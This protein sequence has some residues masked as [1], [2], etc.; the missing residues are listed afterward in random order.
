MCAQSPISI[1]NEKTYEFINIDNPI[2]MKLFRTREAQKQNH[3]DLDQNGQYHTI[4]DRKRP[5]RFPNK[6][7]VEVEQ[8]DVVSPW[9]LAGG[10]LRKPCAQTP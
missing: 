2:G 7:S 3:E 4:V 8:I 1:R 9:P 10:A 6:V 5:I